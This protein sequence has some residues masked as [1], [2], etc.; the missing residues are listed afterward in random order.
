MA[1]SDSIAGGS[2]VTFAIS[3]DGSPIPSQLN[4]LSIQVEKRVNRIARA[5]IVILD[6]QADTGTFDASS[7]STFVPGAEITID[8]GYDGANTTIFK[9]IVTKQSIRIDEAV[10][11]ALEVECRDAAVK[12]II[13]RKSATFAPQKDSDTISSIIGTYPGL[14][15]S[16]TD[17]A[18]TT[19]ISPELVQYYATD[20]DFILSRA[21][22]NGMVVTTLNG[23]VAVFP[24]AADTSSAL[25]VTY[26]Q[27]LM[28]FNADLDA[29]T[30]VSSVKASA[31][32]YTNQALSTAEANNNITGPGNLSGQSLSSVVGLSNYQLQTCASLQDT[33]LTSWGQA[34]VVKIGYAKI[35]G[36]AKFQGT[37][38]VDPGKYITLAGVGDRF[39][40]LHF[41]SGVVHNISNGNWL[42]EASIGM[43]PEW[44]TE[45]PDVVSPS[46]AGLLPGTRGLF[47]GVVTAMYNDPNNQ[48]RIKVNLPLF[49]P[50]QQG[51]WA[52]LSNFYSTSNAGVFFLPEIGDEVVV[53]FL[54]EDPRFPVILGSL[55][56]DSKIKPF[57]GLQPNETNS[58]KA[59][60]SKSGIY[61]QFDD[62]NKVLT[63]QTPGNNKM[64]FNDTDKQI[65]VSDE[66]S[67]SIVMSAE[68]ITIKSPKTIS[69]QADQQI[70]VTGTQGI[71]ASAA[72]GDVQ[73]TGM[74]I[75]GT[76]DMQYS[77]AGG[78]TMALNGG[79]EL[80]M[81]SAMIMIN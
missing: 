29:L 17:T 11:S 62:D 72:N 41:V 20:W 16:V 77:A 7:S 75:K 47:N 32:D 22:A 2:L 4:V 42:T 13:G 58:L 59:I 21:D 46:A 76:A 39:N 73:L 43:S 56:S 27:G 6:G 28:E 67:N 61:I 52:R 71:T 1:N 12:M 45:E 55:Y 57:T 53:G 37:A 19:N 44:F 40:G 63:V 68:G 36:E 74:N 54:N 50:A 26:G 30:Q 33:D 14:S 80:T 5:K 49:D 9:G 31:W 10:G 24:P 8:A 23:T 81:Q 65:S 15:A 78:Q 18:S 64:V 3:A 66:N 69:I 60:V 70:N 35:Q 38:V 79:T 48:Y 51:I 34:Q 25:T